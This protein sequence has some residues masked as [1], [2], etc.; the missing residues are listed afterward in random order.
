MPG[1][2]FEEDP[3]GADFADDTGN[4]RPE[5]A[6]VIFA[7]PLSCLAERLTGVS[8]K[9]GVDRPAEGSSV[10]GGEVVPNRGWREVSGALRCDDDRPGVFLPLDIASSVKSGL[11]E[12][13]A[14]IQASAACAEGQSVCGT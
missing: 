7:A 4:V 9:D 3:C 1:D 12:H 2:V 8:G 13:E 11:C 5:V 6:L 10:E 14:H